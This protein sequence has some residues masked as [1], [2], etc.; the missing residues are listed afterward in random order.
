MYLKEPTGKNYNRYESPEKFES[1]FSYLYIGEELV[2][3][4]PVK[5]VNVGDEICGM[6]VTGTG[7]SFYNN[8]NNASVPFR[9]DSTVVTFKG[10][11]T[12]AGYLS[13]EDMT[14]DYP[15]T[16]GMAT[17]WLDEQS[18]PLP[19]A[20]ISI[21]ESGAGFFTQKIMTSFLAA[22]TTTGE[23]LLLID[24]CL[25]GSHTAIRMFT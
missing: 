23:L 21:G 24:P 9:N 17:F 1:E 19:I 2:N 8:G 25:T 15:G 16:E 22:F 3:E 7:T 13:V 6:T 4:N 20:N 10:E 12:L 5:R 18:A 11:V 14:P